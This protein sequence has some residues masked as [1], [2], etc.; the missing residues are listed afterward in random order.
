MLRELNTYMM[1]GEF[2][3]E[4]GIRERVRTYV[5]AARRVSQIIKSYPAEVQEE[6]AKTGANL[7]AVDDVSLLYDAYQDA[8]N[9]RDE[10]LREVRKHV[11]G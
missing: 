2:Y 10:I 7:A 4:P 11:E 5:D 1:S 3:F 8:Q 9:A 6:H